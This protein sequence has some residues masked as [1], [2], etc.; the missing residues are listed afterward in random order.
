MLRIA[1]DF[2]RLVARSVSPKGAL[3]ALRKRKGEYNTKLLDTLDDFE[4][5]TVNVEIKEVEVRE[6]E[7]G[8]VTNGHI[9]SKKG[10]LLVPMGH[11]ITYTVLERLRNFSRGVGVIEPIQVRVLTQD[12][13]GF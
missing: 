10:T 2:D 12:E 3:S 8:M 5:N 9:K 1:I 7:I 13:F 4:G 6:L 11:E